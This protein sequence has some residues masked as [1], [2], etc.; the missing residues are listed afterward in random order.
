MTPCWSTKVPQ[1]LDCSIFF[2]FLNLTLD[3]VS[4]FLTPILTPLK[5]GSANVRDSSLLLVFPSPSVAALWLNSEP[6]SKS[7]PSA[8]LDTLKER[9]LETGESLFTACWRVVE[10]Y[11]FLHNPWKVILSYT[12]RRLFRLAE[13]LA[14]DSSCLDERNAWIHSSVHRP[15]DKKKKKTES[16]KERVRTGELFIHSQTFQ[17]W[18]PLRPPFALPRAAGNQEWES[19][20]ENGLRLRRPC[21]PSPVSLSSMAPDHSLLAC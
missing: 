5:R 16:E 18:L 21:L 3:A 15:D 20:W 9:H 19:D 13:I 8:G 6:W 4:P 1:D 12:C 11:S 17:I 10:N 7:T 14:Q 2:F